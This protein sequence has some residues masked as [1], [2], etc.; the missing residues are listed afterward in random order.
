MTSMLS[1]ASRVLESK[2]LRGG[3]KEVGHKLVILLRMSEAVVMSLI[4]QVKSLSVYVA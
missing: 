2:V 4:C 3:V 1:I